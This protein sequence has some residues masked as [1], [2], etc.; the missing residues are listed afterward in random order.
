MRIAALLIRRRLASS[1]WSEAA[2]GLWARRSSAAVGGWSSLPESPTRSR[3]VR[4]RSLATRTSPAADPEKLTV[5]KLKE[6][7]DSAG[8]WPDGLKRSSK[9]AELVAAVREVLTATGAHDAA[10]TRSLDRS[11]AD[12]EPGDGGDADIT[13][14]TSL[15]VEESSTVFAAPTD[16]A[17]SNAGRDEEDPVEVLMDMREPGAW[18][19]LARAMRREVHLHV[20]P[21]NSGKTYSAIQQ[22]K[23]ADSGVYCSPLRLLAWEVAEGL[24]NRDGVPCNMITGQEKKPVDGARHVACTVEMADI[25]RMVDVAVVDEAHLMGDPER[26]YAFTRAILGIPAK[27]LHLCGDPAMVPLV[28]KVIE[29]VGDKLTVHRYTRLQPLKVLDTPLRSIKNVR[30]GD[31]LVAFSR[32]AVHQLKRDV[33]RQAGLRACVIYGSLPPEARAAG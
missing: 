27:E 6:I 4:W 15:S 31:C 5:V 25:R 16:E 18:Y 13:A 22:L 26:G 9:K 2:S 33:V 32:K 11:R 3:T 12:P 8:P 1:S 29:E 24:N 10:A 21:T 23:A 19:P 30:S 7:L 17:G 20:G 28:Q 14:A